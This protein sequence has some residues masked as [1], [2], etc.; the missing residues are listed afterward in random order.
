MSSSLYND[1]TNEI[2]DDRD[3]AMNFFRLAHLKRV[4]APDVVEGKYASYHD[5]AFDE[6]EELLLFLR[7]SDMVGGGVVPDD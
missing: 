2:A 3:S 6:S 1:I 7:A 4:T 5:L